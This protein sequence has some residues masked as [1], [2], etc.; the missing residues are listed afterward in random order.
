VEWLAQDNPPEVT[1]INDLRPHMVGKKCWCKPFYDE[2][3]LVHNAL[4]GRETLEFGRKM[5]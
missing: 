4:D 3:V 5:S 2:D 1:P